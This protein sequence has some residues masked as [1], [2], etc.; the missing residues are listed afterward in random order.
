MVPPSICVPTASP[1]SNTTIGTHM[2][3][4]RPLST[5][6]AS[7]MTAG[8]AWFVTTG[9]PSAASVGASIAASKAISNVP[10]NGNT[11]AASTKPS[12]IVSGRPTKSSRSGRP[13]LRLRMP[14]SALAASV[15][16]TI[17]NV[18]SAK[19]RNPSPVMFRRNTPRAS[20]PR[21]KPTATNT[22][23]P[24]IHDR[25]IRPATA[26]WMRRNAANIAAFWYICDTSPIR[27]RKFDRS[28]SRHDALI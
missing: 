4:F 25:S 24:L 15:N 1:I 9:L 27:A 18:S 3:S 21:I 11:I 23:G 14:K 13:R 20:G 8:T 22:I 17:A 12:T 10:S 26:L 7:R 28:P 6:S 5:L 16:K 19:T 2:P